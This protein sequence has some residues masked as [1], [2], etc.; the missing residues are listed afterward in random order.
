M[1]KYNKR[2]KGIENVASIIGKSASN[3]LKLKVQKAKK[4]A[5][6]RGR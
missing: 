2:L 1:K 4:N 3:S 5:N 6:R